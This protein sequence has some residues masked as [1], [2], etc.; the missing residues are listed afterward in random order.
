MQDGKTHRLSYMAQ[1][2]KIVVSLKDLA[3]KVSAASSSALQA[4]LVLFRFCCYWVLMRS[5]R[6]G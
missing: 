5:I 1:V 4:F 3:K 6:E 2:V